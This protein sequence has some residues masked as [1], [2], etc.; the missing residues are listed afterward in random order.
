MRSGLPKPVRSILISLPITVLGCGK[1]QGYI[2]QRTRHR[3]KSNSVDTRPEY[4]TAERMDNAKI[5]G[6]NSEEES[7]D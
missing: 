5:E 1:G 2:P 3:C 7:N 4:D 6:G